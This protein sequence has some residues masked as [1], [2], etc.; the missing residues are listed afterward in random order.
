[1]GSV[2]LSGVR[3]GV[4]FRTVFAAAFAPF[5]AFVVF[6]AARMPMSYD[7]AFN[8]TLPLNLLR[9]KGYASH[10]GGLEP[11]DPAISSG[12]AFL[13]PAALP[14]RLFGTGTQWPMLYTAALCLALYLCLLRRLH[15]A[16]P[17]AALATAI[18]VPFRLWQG[19]NDQVVA[20][21]ILPGPPFGY[22]YQLLGNLPGLLALVVAMSLL[23]KP[24]PLA[25]RRW[26]AVLG[27]TAFAVNAKVMHLIPLVAMVVTWALMPSGDFSAASQPTSARRRR[28]AIGLSLLAAGWCGFW[29][30]R[31]LAWIFLDG[32]AFRDFATQETQFL[33]AHNP[34]AAL[35]SVPGAALPGVLTDAL[36]RNAPRAFDLFGGRLQVAVTLAGLLATG[37]VAL[38]QVRQC[39]IA[40]LGLVLIA[41][42]AAHFTW[43]VCQPEPRSHHLTPVPGLACFALGCGFGLWR[44]SMT[45]AYR[46]R[47]VKWGATLALVCAVGAPRVVGALGGW[48]ELREYR[49][50][51]I[52]AAATLGRLAGEYPDAAFCAPGWWV[53]RQ[54][55]YLAPA[56]TR[57]C[58]INRLSRDAPGRRIL[59]LA[60]NLWPT[61]LDD[62]R[63]AA[64][65]CTV[66]L[67]RDG[68]FEF[69]G[70]DGFVRPGG[71]KR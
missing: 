25:L 68:R 1:M 8:A 58:D 42:A 23:V 17:W 33:I 66:P 6:A 16:A 49:N 31:A 35:L 30:N 36:L 37:A 50:Q 71:S 21:N 53:P 48:G 4:S 54:L 62:V 41:G 27:L 60:T 12:A 14:M 56:D 34:A 38:R 10:F 29:F 70:C 24:G 40:R 61:E 2:W 63:A 52:N 46:W 5:S 43:W 13:A 59:M 55:T 44:P 39:A 64:A 47:Q 57:Y 20:G 45:D 28:A 67:G 69:R 18:L 7:D 65:R 22:W 26:V 9:G 19:K 11:F 3:G 51:Q 32:A 15:R